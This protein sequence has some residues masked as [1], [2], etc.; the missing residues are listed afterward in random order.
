[1]EEPQQYP[2]IKKYI[3]PRDFTDELCR[4]VA[5]K[6]FEGF[7]QG[8]VNPAGIISMFPDE[9]QQREAASF[10]HTKLPYVENDQERTKAF[11]DIVY[12][13]KKNSYESDSQN[14]GSDVAALQRVIEG[15]RMLEE[16]GRT[17]I[18]LS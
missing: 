10:F 5:E 15:K 12:A 3:S 18:S 11:N 7:E 16:L 13:V 17:H 9:E 1:M 8:K 4:L 14:L 2:K 6:L